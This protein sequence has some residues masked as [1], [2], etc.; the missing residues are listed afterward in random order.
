MKLQAFCVILIIEA[1]TPLSL[2]P[3]LLRLSSFPPILYRRFL[4]EAPLLY[5]FEETFFLK[6]ALKIL[7]CLFDVV[8]VNSYFQCYLSLSLLYNDFL[9]KKNHPCQINQ[10]TSDLIVSQTVVRRLP[11][12]GNLSIIKEIS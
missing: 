4:V 9:K 12:E 6:L 7:N 3:S 5:F 1:F 8:V 10:R 11:I 2:H